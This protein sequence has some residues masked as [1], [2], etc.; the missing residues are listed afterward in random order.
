MNI[1][2]ERHTFGDDYTIGDLF[3]DGYFFCNTL[4][5][6][7]REVEGQPVEKWKIYGKTAIPRGKYDVVIDY[8]NRFKTELP[9]LLNVKGFTGIRIHP[10]NTHHDT[11]GCILVGKQASSTVINSRATFNR[12]LGIM[13]MAYGRPDVPISIQIMDRF[14]A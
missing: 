5:D 8:S 9:R 12:L 7:V 14:N 6:T 13:D 4:E 2:I 10:G 1:L 3:V 11:E